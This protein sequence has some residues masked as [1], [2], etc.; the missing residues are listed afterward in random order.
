MI[1][2]FFVKPLNQLIVLEKAYTAI[3]FLDVK[4]YREFIFNFD[5]EIIFSIND[6][7]ANYLNKTIQ[8]IHPL[9]I[10]LNDKKSLQLLY[11]KLS[12]HL[13]EELRNKIST[14]EKDILDIIEIM[15]LE[16]Q[17]TIEYNENIDLTKLL[18]MYQVEVKNI[19]KEN[20]LEFLLTYIKYNCELNNCSIVISFGL[21]NILTND[22]LMVLQNELSIHQISIVDFYLNN[23]STSVSYLTVDSDWNKL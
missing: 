20:Y 15:S 19:K 16:A 13:S 3:K 5:D 4:K 12:T 2:K 6:V 14:L 18:A 22:E 7:T 11:K 10:E 8:I 9:D 1:V 17:C 23:F 21:T